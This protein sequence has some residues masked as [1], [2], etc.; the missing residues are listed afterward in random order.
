MVHQSVWVGKTKIPETLILDLENLHILEYVEIFE[1]SKNGT[2]K[3]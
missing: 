2:L 1:I 3:N